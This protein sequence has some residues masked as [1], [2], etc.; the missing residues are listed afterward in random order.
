MSNLVSLP[1]RPWQPWHG[2][3]S[4]TRLDINQPE[5]GKTCSLPSNGEPTTLSSVTLQ[6]QSSMDRLI[7]FD[8]L[9]LSTIIC[10][11]QFGFQWINKIFLFWYYRLE[12]E[13]LIMAGGEGPRTWPCTD[14]HLKLHHLNLDQILLV[15]PL[16][17]LL[18]PLFCSKTMMLITQLLFW[19]MLNVYTI[20]L[21]NTEENTLMLLVM[22]PDSISKYFW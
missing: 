9:I 12:M 19:T 5:N 16:L 17:H 1:L 2:V 8:I 18:L 7:N 20:L 3:V 21:I 22:P 4:L 15:K 13:M 6:I 10:I 11:L 14:H